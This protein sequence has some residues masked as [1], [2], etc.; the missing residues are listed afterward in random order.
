MT[1]DHTS[2]HQPPS[3]KNE[4]TYDEKMNKI[5]SLVLAKFAI[6]KELQNV[7]DREKFLDTSERH[8]QL[9]PSGQGAGIPDT[10]PSR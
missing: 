4:Q 10:V 9:R 6:K 1:T 7:G 3:N 5:A 2:S 8:I